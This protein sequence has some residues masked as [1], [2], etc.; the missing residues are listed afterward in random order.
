MKTKKLFLTLAIFFAI[1]IGFTACINGNSNYQASYT[2]PAVVRFT[3]LYGG[4]MLLKTA[5]GTYV[6]DNASLLTLAT[7]YDG[8]CIYM[9]FEENSD[10]QTTGG[11]SG[12]QYPVASN[13]NYFPVEVGYVSP[14]DTSMSKTFNFPLSGV[15]FITDSYNQNLSLSP[16]FDGK[17]FIATFA[18][19]GANQELQHYAYMKPDE[20]LDANG[21]R[22]IYLQAFLPNAAS[23]TQDVGTAFAIDVNNLL[24]ASG[25][26]TTININ[27]TNYAMRY[28]K[29]NLQYCSEFKDGAPVFTSLVVNQPIYI[30]VLRQEEQ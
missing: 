7:L 28:V 3:G 11:T 17:F 21:A 23:G 30:Y 18:K 29:V 20:P 14:E 27:S 12:S 15:N 22:N 9:N 26:D 6:P 25:R 1:G 19:L 8:D 2:S 5:Y 24:N 13:I 10:N 16:N 4:G